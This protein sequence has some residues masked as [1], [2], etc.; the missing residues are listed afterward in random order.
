[1]RSSEPLTGAF[2]L[3]SLTLDLYSVNVV[4]IMYN[5]MCMAPHTSPTLFSVRAETAFGH[6]LCTQGRERR[7]CLQVLRGCRTSHTSGSSL[8]LLLLSDGLLRMRHKTKEELIKDQE[9]TALAVAE[10]E[11]RKRDQDISKRLEDYFGKDDDLDANDKF[12]KEY[13]LN[14][15]WMD[16]DRDRVPSYK[17]VVGEVSEDEVYLEEQDKYE[18][19]YNFRFQ[20]N[21]GAQVM[22]NPRLVEGSVRKKGETRK[23]Q[24][25]KKEERLAEVAIARQEELKRL[26]NLKK[27]EIKEKLSKIREVAGTTEGLTALGENDLEEDF[28]PEEY[29]RKMQEAFGEE[30]YGEEDAELQEEEDLGIIE[31]PNFEEE[32]EDLGLP[33]GWEKKAGFAAA[34][35]KQKITLNEK[36]AFDKNLEDYYKLDHEDMIGDLPTRFKYRQVKA[37]KYGLK[38]EDI[39]SVED[40]DLNQHVSIKKLATY[41]TEEWEPSKYSVLSQKARKKQAMQDGGSAKYKFSKRKPDKKEQK[42]EHQKV[43]TTSGQMETDENK[44]SGSS[45]MVENGDRSQT[46]EQE[47]VKKSKRKKRKK[48]GPTSFLPPSRKEA[49]GLMPT[50]SKKRRVTAA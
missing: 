32:D 13:I 21:A 45:H 22:G 38:V 9:E 49:Y 12:L 8:I 44:E 5:Y 29:D 7:L 24:R 2:K 39:L 23:Q 18:A 31:K 11:R 15:G 36:L 10:T 37:N 34:R 41:R 50:P 28:D 40:K 3:H 25:S 47:A 27:K 35:E 19:N 1:M 16:R 48:T 14:Q 4:H 33:K 30:Y 46:S 20:E 17:E 42:R 6:S 26:K 43:E